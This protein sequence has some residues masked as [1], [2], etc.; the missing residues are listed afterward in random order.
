MSNH[1]LGRTSA[2]LFLRFHSLVD[3]FRDDGL[4]LPQAREKAREKLNITT[5]ATPPLSE[6]YHTRKRNISKKV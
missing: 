3:D 6:G 2:E 1:E 4:T 5:P